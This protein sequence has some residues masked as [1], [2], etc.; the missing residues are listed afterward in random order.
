MPVKIPTFVTTEI[1]D[2]DLHRFC[3]ENDWK[4]W[5]KGPY[6]EAVRTRSWAEFQ[7]MRNV[8][9]SAW[10]TDKL[11]LQ[12][13]VFG[14][15]E[16]ISLSAYKGE[17]LDCVRMRKRDLTELSKTWAVK[18]GGELKFWD[19]SAGWWINP[20]TKDGYGSLLAARI[21]AFNLSPDKRFNWGKHELKAFEWKSLM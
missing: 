15:E 17:L 14:Y 8:L 1:S 9:S 7:D 4:A 21:S 10:A 5:L 20:N 13:H 11:F 16:S 19:A 6:Y 12:A 2:W 18:V 3:R